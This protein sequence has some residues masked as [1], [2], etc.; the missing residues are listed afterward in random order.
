MIEN[1]FIVKNSTGFNQNEA[2]SVFV[3]AQVP[4]SVLLINDN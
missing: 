3:H 1:S 2:I 4:I